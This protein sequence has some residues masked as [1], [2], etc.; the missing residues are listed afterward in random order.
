MT[1]IN[2]MTAVKPAEPNYEHMSEKLRSLG[3][4]VLDR[5]PTVIILGLIALYYISLSHLG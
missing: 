4:K 1:N 3:T 5:I 2:T